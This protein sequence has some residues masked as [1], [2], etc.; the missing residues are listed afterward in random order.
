MIDEKILNVLRNNTASHVSGEELCK[1]ADISR[2]AIWK[3][4]EQLREEGYEIEAT[5]HLGYKLISVPDRLIPAE[6]KWKLKTKFLGKNVISYVKVDSTNDVAYGLAENGI[7]EGTVVL[8]EEQAKGKGRHGRRWVS[9]AKG[10]IYMSCVLRPEIAPNEIAKITLVA[11]VSMAKTVRQLTGL[12]AMIKWPNDILVNNK[13]VCGILMEMKAEQ[14]TVK[15]I[16][17]GIGLNVNIPGRHLPKGATS[18]KDE[19]RH[20][21]A[22]DSLSRIEVVKKM[23]ENLEEY[24]FLLKKAGFKPIIDEWKEMSAMVGS[25]IKVVLQNRTFEGQAHDIDDDGALIVRLES[26]VMERVSSGDIIMAR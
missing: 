8:A 7:R 18:L 5:P 24:Y 21:A 11:A 10:G 13:K 26:G 25:R 14:D 19:L 17:L 15:F 2:A 23:L 20:S 4:V 22:R 6:I 9:P 3:H 16:I 1:I 12:T